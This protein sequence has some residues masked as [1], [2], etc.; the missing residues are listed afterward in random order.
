[1]PLHPL[2]LD[3]QH[4]DD[5]RAFD[6]FVHRCRGPHTEPRDA[7]WHQRRRATDPDVR[8]QGLE[9]QQVRAQDAA[10]QQVTDD[11]QLQ[12]A[13]AALVIPDRQRIEECLRGMLMHAVARVDDPRAT[14]PGQQLTGT[15]RG[16]AQH[17]HVGSHRLQAQRRI[18]QRLALHDAR[19]RGRNTQRVGAQSLLRDFERHPS[20]RARLKEHIDDGLAPERRYLLDW[21]GPDLLHHFRRI[22]DKHDFLRR[23]VG[24][25][26][27]MSRAQAGRQLDSFPGG[28]LVRLC[29][30][31]HASPVCFRDPATT[32]VSLTGRLES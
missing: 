14:A 26:Q 16:V 22:E 10:V 32:R 15:G 12:A 8:A 23:Q 9:E 18:H 30:Y 5:I 31:V 7:R 11:R 27:Q 17:D 19:R 1:M 13:D 24:D 4:H 6:G 20:P 3:A 25:A 28:R 2:E 21:P 29:L